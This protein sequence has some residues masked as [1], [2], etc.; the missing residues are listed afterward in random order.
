MTR[1]SDFEQIA[2]ALSLNVKCGTDSALLVEADS[3]SA[4]RNIPSHSVSL[5][6]TDPPYH[7]TK[8]RNITGD[9]SFESDEEYLRWFH[10][11]VTQWKRILRPNGSIF[12]FC[13]SEMAARIEVQLSEEFNILS[14]IVWTKPNDPGFD[15]WKQKMRKE[16]L[17]QWYAHSE[18]VIFAEPATPGNLHRSYFGNFLKAMRLK[19][20]LSGHDLTELTGAYGKV[21]HGGAVSNWETGRNIPSRE[22]YRKLCEV[23]LATGKVETMPE[24]ED[25]IRPFYVDATK[26]F[27]DV[28]TFPSVRPYA[29]KHPA[30][31]PIEMLEHAI[32]ATTFPG[33][34][35]LDCFAG[36]GNTA[37]AAIRLARRAIA[38]EIDTRWT[39]RIAKRLVAEAA[40]PP[41][42]L[43][44]AATNLKLAQLPRTIKRPAKKSRAR[45]ST[46]T[47]P[48][49][50]VM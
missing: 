28:W 37:L 45:G 43:W 41:K 10:E 35:V 12:C 47:Q 49:L 5:I 20:G 23:I 38:I 27:T 26:E 13:A 46:D 33:D 32:E 14:H 42:T 25:V 40:E 1:A 44:E 18:R 36:S 34:I 6:L 48:L 4:I 22:Q 39:G 19:A 30:E 17:R 15:G 50:G 16:A 21:N 7:I 8:K 9:T 2:A 29:G 24:Y 3:L 11:Y 31:K